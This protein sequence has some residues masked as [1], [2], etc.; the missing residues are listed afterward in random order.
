VERCD[1]TELPV[2]S[3]GCAQHRNS[4]GF[5]AKHEAGADAAVSA[6]PTPV[7]TDIRLNPAQDGRVHRADCWHLIGIE[8]FQKQADWSSYR[9]VDAVFTRAHRDLCCS[10]C[11]PGR[12]V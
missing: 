6:M 2:E 3:C 7:S 8:G 10:T 5:N 11:K 12:D 1:L 9:P 4:P